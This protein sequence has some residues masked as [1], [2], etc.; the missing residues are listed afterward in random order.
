MIIAVALLSTT[1]L[2]QDILPYSTPSPLSVNLGSGNDQTNESDEREVSKVIPLKYVKANWA[3]RNIEQLF[4]KQKGQFSIIGDDE[5]QI[6]VRAD[7]RLIDEIIEVVVAIDRPEEPR[8]TPSPNAVAKGI[9]EKITLK[10]GESPEGRDRLKAALRKEFEL[11]QNQLRESLMELSTR[12]K[13]AQE[14][15]ER[16]DQLA[17]EIIDLR[18]QELTAAKAS[19][20]L[21][22]AAESA[23][24]LPPSAPL[25]ATSSGLEATATQ[26]MRKP[27]EYVRLLQGYWM[28]YR[29]HTQ[30]RTSRL[31]IID[32]L[33]KVA[34][35]D[36]QD[37]NRLKQAKQDLAL[38]EEYQA[39]SLSD[40]KRAWSEYQTQLQLL[41][42]D[43][44]EAE[45][46]LSFLARKVEQANK[47]YSEGSLSQ[48][49]LSEQRMRLDLAVIKVER[50]QQ[51][52]QLFAEIEKSEPELNP[53]DVKMLPLDTS[54]E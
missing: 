12:V 32:K 5:K 22:P 24:S 52:Y 25:S 17:D 8:S 4:K 2:G 9:S 36:S 41:R 7:R 40:W 13:A 37:E 44:Q 49:E 21:P 38:D 35:L 1:V 6:V 20:V 11:T 50:A 47:Q 48:T 53:N 3:V 45:K 14:L 54:A 42:L 10:D 46:H 34:N 16:R 31:A 39:R 18:F 28:N 43:I 19:G 26:A 33:S 23:R 29:S 15:L 30:D 51:I 27:D